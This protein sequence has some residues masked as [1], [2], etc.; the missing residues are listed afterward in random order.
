MPRTPGS[1]EKQMKH[2][3]VDLEERKCGNLSVTCNEPAEGWCHR[4][5][6]TSRMKRDTPVLQVKQRNSDGS[7]ISLIS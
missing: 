5:L 3:E 7:D 6:V 2:K 4:E 1:G